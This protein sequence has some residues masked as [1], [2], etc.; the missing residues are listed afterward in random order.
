MK[1]NG[2]IHSISGPVFCLLFINWPVV[3]VHFPKHAYFQHLLSYETSCDRD[4]SIK[5]SLMQLLITS[6][7]LQHFLIPLA[8]AHTF[9]SVQFVLSPSSE[10][11]CV[12]SWI[13]PFFP[14]RLSDHDHR[15]SMSLPGLVKPQTS[16]N[17][18]KGTC[19]DYLKEQLI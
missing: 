3:F 15:S 14:Q 13:T 18:K 5:D 7:P 4:C 11:G 1:K 16:Y 10:L 12:C 19:S 9:I 17:G 2:F 8:H 6:L